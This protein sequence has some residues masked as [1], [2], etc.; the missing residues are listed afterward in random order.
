MFPLSKGKGPKRKSFS[1]VDPEFKTFSVD[2]LEKTCRW[3]WNVSRP[4]EKK[5][6]LKEGELRV[7]LLDG[8]NYNGFFFLSSLSNS[9]AT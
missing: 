8:T 9:F 3:S 1:V 2:S 5:V 6:L 4:C 7:D